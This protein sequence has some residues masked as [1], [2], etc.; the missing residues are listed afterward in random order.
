MARLNLNSDIRPVA[1]RLFCAFALLLAIGQ[2]GCEAPNQVAVVEQ[3][4]F[5]TPED[6]VAALVATLDAG[7]LAELKAILGPEC[8][9]LMSSGDAVADQTAKKG[10]LERFREQNRVER[11]ADDAAYLYVG[12]QDWPLPIPLVKFEA[13]WVFD[14]ETG[15]EVIID[16]RVGKNELN[17]IQVCRAYVD[18]QQEYWREDW[19]GDG[20]LEYSQKFPSEPGKKDGLYWPTV[21]GEKPSPLGLLAAQAVEE[22]YKAKDAGSGSSPF[23]GYFFRI[24]TAQGPAARGGA[25]DYVVDGN[26]L[27]GAA[28]IAYPAEYDSSGVVSFLVNHE[29]TVYQKDLG[30]KTHEAAS[31][32]KTFD[33][34]KSWSAV[35][36]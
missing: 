15:K 24:L 32:I 27:G 6:G 2:L 35:A 26:L 28:L 4:A 17:A 1:C 23:H 5:K 33:P 30:E 29:G 12:N 22:G 13:G 3:K 8:D 36:E 21:E 20:L 9:D 19:D 16:R 25:E 7:N 18:A 34:D 31:G 14:T 11:V 10:F